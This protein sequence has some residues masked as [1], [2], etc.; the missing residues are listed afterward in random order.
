M[1]VYFVVHIK[2]NDE[3]IYHKYLDEC[4]EIFKRYDLLCSKINNYFTN[5]ES[6]KDIEGWYYPKPRWVLSRF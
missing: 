5:N 3:T 6:T 2:M 1:S 4:D